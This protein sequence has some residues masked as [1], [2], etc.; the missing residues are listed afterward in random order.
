M[1]VVAMGSRGSRKDFVDLFFY[2]KGGASL[3]GVLSLLTRR[4]QDVDYNTYHL[5]K[6]LVYFADA[7]EEPMPRMI[8]PVTWDEVKEFLVAEVR[9]LS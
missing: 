1:K 5:L 9:R 7:E 3:D 6:S 4:F 2:L 8:R